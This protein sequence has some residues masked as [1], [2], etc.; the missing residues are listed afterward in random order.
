MVN[1]RYSSYTHA[2]LDDEIAGRDGVLV[3]AAGVG[4][5]FIFGGTTGAEFKLLQTEDVD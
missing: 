2:S 1:G 3:K 4:K 5:G